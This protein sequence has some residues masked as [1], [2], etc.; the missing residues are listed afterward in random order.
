MQQNVEGYV[1]AILACKSGIIT[2]TEPKVITFKSF[3]LF[4]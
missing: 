4:K 2:G 3:V 1:M